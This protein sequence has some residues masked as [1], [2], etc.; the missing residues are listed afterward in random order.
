MSQSAGNG[1]EHQQGRANN[2]WPPSDYD[3]TIRHRT[4]KDVVVPGSNQT[5]LYVFVALVRFYYIVCSACAQINNR[6][7]PT[8]HS[9]SP[10]GG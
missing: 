10:S 6:S 5:H 4:F 3:D 2:K 8:T 1:V 7:I 9:V